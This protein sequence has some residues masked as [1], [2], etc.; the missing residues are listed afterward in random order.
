VAVGAPTGTVTFLFTDIEGSTRMWEATPEAMRPALARHDEILRGA[1]DRHGGYL[2][3]TGGDGFAAAFSRAADAVAAAKDA[4][5]DLEAERWPEG[6]LVRVR[7]GLHSGEVEERGGDYFGRAVNWAAR[8]MSAAHGGQVLCSGATAALLDTEPLV[9]LGD[10][11][12]R[13]LDRPVHVFQVGERIFPA[14]RE[15]D[16]TALGWTV[17][18]GV[19]PATHFFGRAEELRLV[20]ERLRNGHVVTLLGVGGAGKTRLAWEVAEKLGD[21]FP[22]GVARADLASVRSGDLVVRSVAHATGAFDASVDSQGDAAIEQRVLATLADKRVLLI[23]DNCEHVV[24]E[25]ARL[26]RLIVET[27]PKVRILATSREPL[28]LAA[29]HRLAVGPL[30][31]AAA[32]GLFCARAEAVAAVVDLEA[33]APVID[34]ICDRVDR[35]ALAVELAAARARMM[36][37][38]DIEQRLSDALPLLAS[39]ERSAT[40]RQATMQAALE[41]SYDLLDSDEQALFAR[42]AVFSGG[43]RL[44]AAEVVCGQQPGGAFDV[45]DVLARLVDKSLVAV[46]TTAGRYRFLEPVRQFA[47]G[48]LMA[49]NEGPALVAAHRRHYRRVAAEINTRILRSGLDNDDRAELANFRA[50]IHR[51]LERGDG[52]AALGVF[53]TLGWYWVATGLFRE[54][55]E[56]GRRS[57]GLASGCDAPLE[58]LGQAMVGGYLAYSG[59]PRESVPHADRATELLASVPH[60]YGARYLLACALECL[61]RSPVE[62]LVQAEENALATGDRAFAAYIAAAHARYRMLMWEPDEAVAPLERARSYVGGHTAV[63]ADVLA[64]KQLAL[65][66]LTG[67]PVD[68]ELLRRVEDAPV[69]RSG[70]A[71]I[72][73]DR[74]LALVL[75][76]E[77]DRAAA[78][79][80][81]ELPAFAQAGWMQIVMLDLRYAAVTQ[82][83]LGHPEHA[84]ALARAA[85][86]ACEELG[87]WPLPIMTHVGADHLEAAIGALTPA[88]VARARREGDNLGINGAVDLVGALVPPGT[89]PDKLSEAPTDS[90]RTLVE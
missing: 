2:F 76:G 10:H 48:R 24:G 13:D 68:G 23:V 46:D 84:V 3:S 26:C 77:P 27:C 88:E 20:D 67:R 69:G 55:V 79:L 19:P 41:W 42:L 52:T 58:L 73:D 74:S 53:V 62:V 21:R 90:T 44:D 9:D 51:A 16:G 71:L 30:D 64:V 81:R 25:V 75:A 34:A 86:R 33:D 87:Y 80:A 49:S 37:L 72:I 17:S 85:E 15:L 63:F 45:I 78:A 54:A 28:G 47:W 57:L 43:W 35:L 8:L 32:R 66:A 29:E 36:S 39:A 56:W 31:V 6:A 22:D 40:P 70:T 7:M 38:R 11:V 89:S 1:I 14:L 4:Q 83:R 82:A 65:D 59:R 61:G 18:P 5:L 60:E 12:L 50:A